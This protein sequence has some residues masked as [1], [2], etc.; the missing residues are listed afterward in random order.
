MASK[1]TDLKDLLLLDGLSIEATLTETE[2]YLTPDIDI[3]KN[4]SM[5]SVSSSI[6]ANT[7][8]PI[9][10]HLNTFSIEEEAEEESDL[11]NFSICS[12]KEEEE[13]EVVHLMNEYGREKSDD[14]G[15]N[16]DTEN[17]YLPGRYQRPRDSFGISQNVGNASN[18]LKQ[19]Q[20]HTNRQHPI[21]VQK[22][23]PPI[24]PILN[25]KTSIV[26]PTDTR[27]VE[28]VP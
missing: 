17:N 10:N 6:Y 19:K 1:N 20:P 28:I 18:V 12:T 9:V 8:A 23:Q 14:L 15:D 27:K 24:Q 21:E 13:S 3:H 7:G 22:K 4:L 26:S 25:I 16:E 2:V 5:N 11:L